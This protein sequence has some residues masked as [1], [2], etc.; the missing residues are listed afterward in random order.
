MRGKNGF[1]LQVGLF[2]IKGGRYLDFV[3]FLISVVDGD[4]VYMVLES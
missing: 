3:E 4:F 2:F 1:C